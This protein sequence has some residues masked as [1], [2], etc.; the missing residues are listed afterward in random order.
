MT[1]HHPIGSCCTRPQFN[2]VGGIDC[3]PAASCSQG[4]APQLG[5]PENLASRVLH[6]LRRWSDQ[7]RERAVTQA[8]R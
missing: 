7:V 4:R 8:G 1:L 6:V 3:G 5:R 2:H